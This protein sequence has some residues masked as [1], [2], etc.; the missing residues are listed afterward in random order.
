MDDVFA[1]GALGASAVTQGFGFLY[2]QLGEVLGRRR[3]R[4]RP[5]GDPGGALDGPVGELEADEAVV[6]ERRTQLQRLDGE[7][8]P[9]AARYLTDTGT[10]LPDVP[11]ERLLEVLAEL[12]SALEAV[13]G[14]RFTLVGE[15][16]EPT[17][18]RIEV[19]QELGRVAGSATG[20]R[21]RRIAGDRG[22][23]V[24][25][26]GTSVEAGAEVVGVRIDDIE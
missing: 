19:D 9:Y 10:E 7:L 6:E 21:A 11:D 1:W 25:Q 8:A 2:A 3:E 13:Y 14:R 18:T 4:S 5:E 23:S 16:R 20:V 17:G 15:D 12:R 24:R 26:R 22:I